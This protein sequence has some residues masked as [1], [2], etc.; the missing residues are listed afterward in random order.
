MQLKE[1][2]IF[3]FSYHMIISLDERSR[4]IMKDIL[5]IIL[6]YA[7]FLKRFMVLNDSKLHLAKVKII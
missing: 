2:A 3:L 1:K 6:N 7:S 5:K 4:N